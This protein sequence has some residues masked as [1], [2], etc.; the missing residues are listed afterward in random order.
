[1][2]HRTTA[3]S[4]IAL[5][6]ASF[7]STIVGYI[8]FKTHQADLLAPIVVLVAGRVAKGSTP[9]IKWS[10]VFMALYLLAAIAVTGVALVNPA[11]IFVF[12]RPAVPSQVLLVMVA[13]LA[14]GAWTALNIVALSRLLRHAPLA[15]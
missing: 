1:L 5:C 10:L 4:I 14:G 2:S 7:L 8:L 13:S 9:A 12:G 6:L 3:L 11:S 15:A